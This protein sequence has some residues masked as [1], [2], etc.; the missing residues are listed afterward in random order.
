M[1]NKLKQLSSLARKALCLSLVVQLSGLP[2]A[3]AAVANLSPTRLQSKIESHFDDLAAK[4][5][6]FLDEQQRPVSAANLVAGVLK[7]K[8][9]YLVTPVINDE[10]I[11]TRLTVRVQLEAPAA[12]H[13]AFKMAV[14][15]STGK[16]ALS[17]RKFVIDL[18]PA[19]AQATKLRF[20]RTMNSMT[21][22]IS[23]HSKELASHN[24]GQKIFTALSNF[25]VPSAHAEKMQNTAKMLTEVA[26]GAC[27]IGVL[28]LMFAD[29]TN[30]SGGK[31][32][33][34][35]IGW[36]TVAVFVVGGLSYVA[37]G[38]VADLDLSKE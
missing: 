19:K 24:V 15:D 27:S 34:N 8:Q 20:E 5:W 3:S 18:D 26:G 11:Q 13:I 6:R 4:N 23:Q 2:M 37:S 31:T 28:L 30:K 32:R 17:Q 10:N 35:T 29:L 9:F 14:M 38:I 36:L 22:E 7:T 1:K 16:K 33:L 12:E 21:H 25:L